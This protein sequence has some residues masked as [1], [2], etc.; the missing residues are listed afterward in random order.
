MH[1]TVCDY[2]TDLMQCRTRKWHAA[3]SNPLSTKISSIH[4]WVRVDALMKYV[5]RKHSQQART[6]YLISNS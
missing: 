5:Q 1:A 3:E 4:H 6:E 2:G